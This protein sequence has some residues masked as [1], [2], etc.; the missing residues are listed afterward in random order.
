MKIL[1]VL[2]L[3]AGCSSRGISPSQTEGKTTYSYTDVAGTYRIA[4]EFKMV[5]QRLVSRNVLLSSGSDNKTLEKS[6]TV[7]KLG[8]IRSNKSRLITLR[9]EAS[10]FSVWLEGKKYSSSMR[11]NPKTKSMR[12]TL[13][14]PESRWRGTQEIPFP[15]GKFFCFYNQIPECLYRN[16]LLQNAYDTKKKKLEFFVIWDNYPYLQDQLSHVG[17]NLFAP[18]TL[19]FDGEIKNNFRYIVEVEGQII[20][21]QF[22]KSLDL[23]KMAWIAQGITMAVPGDDTNSAEEM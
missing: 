8:S 1:L 10:E 12:V 6:I 5:K 23:V 17:K 21:Y 13:D 20:L 11:I 18:A 19:K 9:P 4:R 16:S 15:K 3:A 2:L 14:S 7:S 22:T